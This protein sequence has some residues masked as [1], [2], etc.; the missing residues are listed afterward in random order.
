M[1]KRQSKIIHW[2]LLP[3]NFVQVILSTKILRVYTFLLWKSCRLCTQLVDK[4]AVYDQITAQNS[5][6]WVKIKHVVIIRSSYTERGQKYI[7]NA[8]GWGGRRK[9]GEGINRRPVNRRVGVLPLLLLQYDL[10]FRIVSL[11]FSF[12][13]VWHAP[14]HEISRTSVMLLH[15]FH[16]L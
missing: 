10:C 1:R 14:D 4:Q 3:W 5:A 12:V 6:S 7:I 11:N 8:K 13:G 16:F 15:R 9:R 2:K